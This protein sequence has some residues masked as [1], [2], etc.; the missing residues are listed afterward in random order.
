[1]NFVDTLDEA[2]R[3]IVEVSAE[4]GPTE[5]PKMDFPLT[6]MLGVHHEA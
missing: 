4:V 3:T 5:A 2:W 6:V 1:M